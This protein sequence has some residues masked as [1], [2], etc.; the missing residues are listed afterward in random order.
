MTAVWRAA[1]RRQPVRY[2]VSA[3][4]CVLVNNILLIVG[5]G[6]HAPYVPL[7]AATSWVSGTIGYGL[8]SR[9]TFRQRLT[10]GGYAR[11]LGGIALAFPIALGLLAA[12]ISL[13]GLAMWIAAPVATVIML[14]YNY[15]NARFATLRRPLPV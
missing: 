7:L 11:F 14:A 1:M 6:L 5:D 13:A 3:A 10:W 2:F 4:V 8:H 15:L 9:L 12:L